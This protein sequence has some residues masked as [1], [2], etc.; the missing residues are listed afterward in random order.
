MQLLWVVLKFLMNIA[1]KEDVVINYIRTVYGDKFYELLSRLV[2]EASELENKTPLE[3]RKWVEE[4]A[5]SYVSEY[6][7]YAVRM[8]IE[9]VLSVLRK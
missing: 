5:I 7:E 6:G 9:F 1:T 3:R 2:K 8:C 4:Q